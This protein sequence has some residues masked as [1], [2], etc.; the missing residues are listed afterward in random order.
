[1]SSG[2]RGFRVRC[3]VA[4]L[5]AGS[6]MTVAI[7][8]D[9]SA[10]IEDSGVLK[11]TS[12]RMARIES[13]ELR[14][15]SDGSRVLSSTTVGEGGRYR[16]TGQWSYDAEW[17]ATGAR[18]QGQIDGTPFEVTI[19][20]GDQGA[21]MRVQRAEGERDYAAACA[22]DCLIDLAPSALPMF[23]MTRRY[24]I[25]R[26]GVQ[27]FRWVGHS[28][29]DGQVLLDGVARIGRVRI[30]PFRT[31]DGAAV[32]VQQ[33]AFVETLR[34]EASG[35]SFD[36]AFNLYV[37]AAHRP[38]AFAIGGSTRGERVG[39]EGLVTALPFQAP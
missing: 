9:R 21:R 5:S 10:T 19:E 31:A 20:R 12:A 15:A 18:G 33:F 36:V 35:R 23:T 22:D 11:V 32:E 8:A 26:G 38:L 4:A 37:D 14:R 17:V 16:V 28:L 1:M 25:G 13:F 27:T 30:A 29:T 7:A 24:D 3:V 39:Y 34:D 6:L 2:H